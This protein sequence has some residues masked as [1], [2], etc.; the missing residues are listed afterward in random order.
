MAARLA[1]D[2][3]TEAA[4][5]KEQRRAIAEGH[6]RRAI[7][8]GRPTASHPTRV[9]SR[10][11]REKAGPA[12]AIQRVIR[13]RAARKRLQVRSPP[14]RCTCP[15][16]HSNSST[17]SH[18]GAVQVKPIKGIDEISGDLMFG[19]GIFVDG[20]LVDVA[21][22][23]RSPVDTL[24]TGRVRRAVV[25]LGGR[26][27]DDDTG[28]GGS[29]G[30]GREDGGMS[31]LDETT[32]PPADQFEADSD[33]S[34]GP[35]SPEQPAEEDATECWETPGTGGAAGDAEAAAALL[36]GGI[37]SGRVSAA[38]VDGSSS[39]P[40]MRAAAARGRVSRPIVHSF[41]SSET[42]GSE[43]EMFQDTIEQG[44]PPPP[45][46]AASPARRRETEGG[47]GRR[48]PS[49][50]EGGQPLQTFSFSSDEGEIE[51]IHS[52]GALAAGLD[53]HAL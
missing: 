14:G 36:G 21:G 3:A 5:L 8:A 9:E 27:S 22:T 15:G 23:R 50:G 13:G 11:S 31:E 38:D 33:E 1:A 12:S 19:T 29:E 51:E 39:P 32:Q 42:E 26:T 24:L 34:F 10:E 49:R 46:P 4:R 28:S 40:G 20:K 17:L 2:E 7:A 6:R 52:R 53:A 18:P 16:S 30:S 47:G 45:P 44:P 25:Q 35:L 48:S 41:S 43:D 37:G